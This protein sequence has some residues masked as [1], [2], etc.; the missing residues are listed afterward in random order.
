ML[1]EWKAFD[2]AGSELLDGLEKPDN[3]Y[4]A[5]E[6]VF[7]R[8]LELGLA[9]DG[10]DIFITAEFRAPIDDERLTGAFEGHG[11]AVRLHIVRL[12]KKEYR[13]EGKSPLRGYL[14]RKGAGGPTEPLAPIV[15]D[16][17]QD[18]VS[19]SIDIAPWHNN[20]AVQNLLEKY[21]VT[22]KL[23]E[24]MLAEGLAYE[25]IDR[26]LATAE[27]EKMAP[28]EIFKALRQSG[29][30]TEQFLKGRKGTQTPQTPASTE[31]Q[32]LPDFLATEFNRP[33]G[34]LSSYLRKGIPFDDLLALLVLEE[35]GGGT[36]E[37]L[38][39][40]FETTD[41]K[42]LVGRT[43]IDSAS[44]TGR[45]EQLQELTRQGENKAGLETVGK[46]AADMK[47]SKGEVLY[48]L[49]KGYSLE[50][51]REILAEKS[52]RQGLKELIDI[53]GGES[54]SDKGKGKGKGK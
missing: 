14:Q 8:C 52:P 13:T 51:A 15:L 48:I 33:A 28:S 44:F 35:L 6:A 20:S 30:S 22:G 16:A 49:A 45:L 10:Q 47:V 40:D 19:E 18:G 7:S 24:K 31:P 3:V 50:A 26:L 11:V 54:H 37:K 43:D 41:L 27:A 34:Q 42:T 29:K 4:V 5:I 17:L 1:K 36:L 12:E 53:R 32:W 2:P 46:L 38:K 9:K 39:K 25:E 21:L 23:V